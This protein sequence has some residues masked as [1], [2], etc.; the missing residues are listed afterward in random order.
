LAAGSEEPTL[1]TG[2]RK[3]V[4]GIMSRHR[5]GKTVGNGFYWNTSKWEITVVPRGGAVLPGDAGQAYVRVPTILFLFLAPFMG[6]AYVIFLPF[7][8]FVLVIGFAARKVSEGVQTA[9]GR[10]MTTVS[11][12]W[13]PGEAYL[14]G[15]RPENES[16]ESEGDKARRGIEERRPSG[17]NR[18]K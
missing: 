16:N 6:A 8:G 10:L 11:P 3:P 17:E 12:R 13:Q 7:V 4:E 18:Q 15:D 5:G 2:Y 1:L 14:S 9:F